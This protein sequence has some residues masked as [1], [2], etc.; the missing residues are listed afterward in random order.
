MVVE[1]RS[2]LGKAKARARVLEVG[3]RLQVGVPRMVRALG[4]VGR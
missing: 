4:V 1:A 2:L 3:S